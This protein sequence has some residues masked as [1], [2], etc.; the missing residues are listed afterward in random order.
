M[1]YFINRIK[2]QSMRALKKF[3]LE[4]KF[5]YIQLRD[6]LN[7]HGVKISF[8]GLVFWCCDYSLPKHSRINPKHIPKLI[9][10]TG[11][12]WSDFYEDLPREDSAYE[13]K[14]VAAEVSASSVSSL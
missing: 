11:Y 14:A 3:K 9:E 13:A 5:T 12:S 10:I 6:Y 1:T 4:K 7:D 2:I 8:N